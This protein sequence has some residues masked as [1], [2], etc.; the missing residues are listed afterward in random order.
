MCCASQ[1]RLPCSGKREL[2]SNLRRS[3]PVEKQVWQLDQMVLRQFQ[4]LLEAVGGLMKNW[5][6]RSAL[7]LAGPAAM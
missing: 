4:E 3:P 6:G 7:A 1:G 5:N 2:S